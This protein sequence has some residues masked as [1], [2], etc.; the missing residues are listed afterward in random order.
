MNWW[1]RFA[2]SFEEKGAQILLL[3]ITDMLVL[4]V[5]VFYW[6][7]FDDTLQTTIVGVLS[8]INGAFLGATGARA[9]SNG[10]PPKP[11]KLDVGF[12]SATDPNKKG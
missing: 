9:L 6:K 5:L 8:G 7:R 1:E 10:V 2:H 12:I 11:D 4:A 3:W